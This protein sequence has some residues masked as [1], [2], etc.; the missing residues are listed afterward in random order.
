MQFVNI[1]RE[2]FERFTSEHFSHYTQ[3]VKHYNYRRKYQNDVHLVGVKDDD[4][5]VL[6]ACLLTEAPALKVYR[7]FYT[8]RGP[9]MDYTNIPL[10]EFFFKELTAYLKRLNAL[11]VL[12][13]P[14][15]LEN[16]RNTE[17]EIIESFDNR[18]WMRTL[19]KLG[20][21]HQGYT[22]GYSST[23]QIRWLSVLD[24]KGKS[25]DQ[26]LKEMDYQ[27]RRNIKK[28]YEMGVKV[29]TLPIEDTDTFF[30]LFRMAEERHGF[31]FKEKDYFYIMQNIYEENAMLKLA[32]VD[33]NEYLDELN[34]KHDDL[35][36]ELNEV[37]EALKEN[38]NSKK[39]KNKAK[40]LEQ[41]VNSSKKKIDQTEAL[42]AEHGDVL[43][44]ASALYI[45]NDHEV[46]Y[47]SSGSNPEFNRFMGAYRLQWEMIK[48]AKD[49][50][51]DRYNF[52]GITGDFSD[53]AEDYGVQQFKKGFNAH[54]EEYIGDFIKPIQP[55]VYK[56][57]K[58]LG[59]L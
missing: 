26:L 48:F 38:S 5:N 9:V 21:K 16:Y 24:L 23:S 51:I 17:G 47:L 20:Y 34:K 4:G 57:A 54:V 12:V 50:G 7:Y 2:E 36:S 49:H 15:E 6:A 52:Y 58:K 40:Q 18:A 14:Y 41:Q 10:V 27:T 42:K 44:L 59:R 28:T 13:D 25:E 37:N 33:L 56:L 45:Y 29:K 39:Q 22:V 46:Y 53:D 32:Y 31:K 55:T 11:F 19:E 3:L 35:T 30:K 8:H 43:N 1:S